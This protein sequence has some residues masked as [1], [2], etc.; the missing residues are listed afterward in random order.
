MCSWTA[1]NAKFNFFL[2]KQRKP[3]TDELTFTSPRVG[4][5]SC[6]LH[7]PFQSPEEE[8]R[9]LDWN[10]LF[11]FSFSICHFKLFHINIFR[12][13]LSIFN[14][15]CYIFFRHT[16]ASK[17]TILLQGW[18]VKIS[19]KLSWQAWNCSKSVVLGDTQSMPK[20]DVTFGE[21][22]LHDCH[23]FVGVFYHWTV[24]TIYFSLILNVPCKDLFSEK[25]NF[26]EK[27]I[28]FHLSEPCAIWY[29][30]KL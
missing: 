27:Q 26:V 16:K 29:S 17:R 23:L 22:C 5:Q 15:F 7:A 8:R 20:A 30:D 4:R 13:S 12:I 2:R 9:Q 10:F 11:F 14:S 1:K 19:D 18:L 25:L 6:S 3:K 21:F 24:L 28:S